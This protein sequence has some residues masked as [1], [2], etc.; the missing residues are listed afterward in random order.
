MGVSG[1]FTV[2]WMLLGVVCASA[3]C[4]R[5]QV[6]RAS[7]C[8]DDPEQPECVSDGLDSDAAGTPGTATLG[9]VRIE[10]AVAFNDD[11][12]RCA[13]DVDDPDGDALLTRLWTRVA[14]GAEI[15]TGEVLDLGAGDRWPPGELIRC[16]AT[17]V[18]AGGDL[19][20]DAMI[21]LSNRAPVVTSVTV[22]PDAPSRGDTVTCAAE[23]SDADGDEPVLSY[24]WSTGAT[25]PS[26]TVSASESKG[27][28]L[29]CTATAA[30]AQDGS[31]TDRGTGSVEVGNTP[32]WFNHVGITPTVA[33]T[34]D[35]L[36]AVVEASDSDGDDL[37]F[38]YVWRVNG[39]VVPG[40]SGVSLGASHFVKGDAVVVSVTADDGSATSEGVSSP[41]EIANTVP[42]APVV[43]VT[44]L[45]AVVGDALTCAVVTAP[46]DPDVDDGVDALT[47]SFSWTVDGSPFSGAT[48]GANS[49][50]VSGDDV[51][52][53]ELWACAV[54]ASD[55]DAAGEA[56]ASDVFVASSERAPGAPLTTA[57]LGI[58]R[59]VPA[60]SFTM[61][62]VSPGD[63]VGGLTSCSL[64]WELPART[65]TLTQ[66]LWM[67]E[68]EL[69]QGM[70]TALGFTNPSGY[71][72]GD[73][74]VETVNWW[75]AI[76]AANE[77]SRR[78]GL[79]V[80][81]TV[82]GCDSTDVGAGRSCTG[83]SVTSWS[84]HPKDC[85]GWRL[86]TEVEWEYAARA[87]TSFPYSGGSAETQVAWHSGNNS[88]AGTKNVCTTPTPRN[89][90]GLCDMSGNVWEWAWDRYVSDY[91]GAAT[92]DPTGP[93][94]GSDRVC[95]SGGWGDGPQFVRVAFRFNGAPGNRYAYLGF[96]LVRSAP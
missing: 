69:T 79:A 81:Y 42:G 37:S 77:A 40:E 72:G 86:P 89:A 80:C 50:V 15:G 63:V 56:G 70:W 67:M 25:G 35:T 88:P 66:A 20:G 19:T 31:L 84:G 57:R 83:V 21:T 75:E 96:R 55:G 18:R 38:G 94:S 16:R 71:S 95:R 29:V 30:D 14:S 11:V 8:E 46:S 27:T 9:E 59:Y 82:M 41:V 58:V 4:V 48:G 33:R 1:V 12:L 76:E 85:E 47:Y 7:S 54:V 3:G 68:S 49:S 26:I 36:T 22:S 43:E 73:R 24:A 6:T 17:R 60:G 23:A 64:G 93:T 52:V 92:I 65:V 28:V 32:P 91:V 34:T 78:D 44:P 51:G 5:N 39:E 2:R 53:E 87:G 90:W 10:P 61:G 62:C 13:V 74:P 45:D